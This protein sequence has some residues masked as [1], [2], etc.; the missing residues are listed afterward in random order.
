MWTLNCQEHTDPSILV[1]LGAWGNRRGG[2]H[3]GLCFRLFAGCGLA[4]HRTLGYTPTFATHVRHHE[5]YEAQ[6]HDRQER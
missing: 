2:S 4:G 5:P 1:G 6:S 3:L